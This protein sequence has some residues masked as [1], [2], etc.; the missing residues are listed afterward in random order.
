M[1][2]A[3]ASLDAFEGE[4]SEDEQSFPMADNQSTSLAFPTPESMWESFKG[5]SS[6][7]SSKVDNNFISEEDLNLSRSE[8]LSTDEFRPSE[9]NT[10]VRRSSK[11]KKWK[12]EEIKRLIKKRAELDD[13]FQ[14]VKGRMILWEEVSASLSDHGINRTPAQC[15]SLWASLVQKYE[16]T[17]VCSFLSSGFADSTFR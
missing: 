1:A 13:R 3:I 9:P 17:V 11:R 5:P 8:I 10:E 2:D 16:V 4:S 14:A 7:Q 6:V 12:P 15:K